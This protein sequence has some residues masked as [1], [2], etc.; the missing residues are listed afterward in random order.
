ME[1]YLHK[2][3]YTQTVYILDY[4]SFY[5]VASYARLFFFSLSHPT[6]FI[7][8][9]SVVCKEFLVQAGTI[10]SLLLILIHYSIQQNYIMYTRHVRHMP[11]VTWCR[12]LETPIF[13]EYWTLQ[14][15][16]CLLSYDNYAFNLC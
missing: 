8:Y 14:A 2:Y 6:F 1:S 9:D 15:L 7:H 13:Y 4:K 10:S 3:N 5:A 11:L 12:S 16:R